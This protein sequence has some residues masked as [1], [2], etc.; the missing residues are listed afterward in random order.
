MHCHLCTRHIEILLPLRS[1]N[2][3]Y[4][5]A[6]IHV[7]TSLLS[8]THRISRWTLGDGESFTSPHESDVF[9]PGRRIFSA[10]VDRSRDFSHWTSQADIPYVI[11]SH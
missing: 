8:G 7:V 9:D 3:V 5:H 4:V 1:A 10:S 6:L 11:L 2:S